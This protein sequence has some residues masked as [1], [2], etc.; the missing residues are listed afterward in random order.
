MSANSLKFMVGD[1]GFEPVAPD[2]I[3]ES[4]PSENDKKSKR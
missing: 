2:Q 4:S 1:A 3:A